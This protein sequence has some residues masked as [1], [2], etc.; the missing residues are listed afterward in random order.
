MGSPEEN[1]KSVSL[2]EEYSGIFESEVD[3]AVRM[4]KERGRTPSPI[5]IQDS[6]STGVRLHSQNHNRNETIDA[7]ESMQGYEDD[8]DDDDDG[9]ARRE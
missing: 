9:E 3:S 8:F 5:R 6:I 7:D 4:E 2:S 1:T